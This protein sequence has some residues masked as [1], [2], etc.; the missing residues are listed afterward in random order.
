MKQDVRVRVDQAGHQSH[1]RQFDYLCFRW[2]FDFAR[3]SSGFDL[4]AAHQH[5]PTVVQLRRL[6]VEDVRR[7]EQVNRVGRLG[8]R[9]LCLRGWSH[10]NERRSND[11]AQYGQ[12]CTTH[13]MILSMAIGIRGG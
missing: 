9:S 4:L 8:R 5:H 6:A 7:L 10:L 2:S 3:R 13:I 1:P 11:E 12:K